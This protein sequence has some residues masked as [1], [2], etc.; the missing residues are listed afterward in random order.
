MT[1]TLIISCIIV[2]ST[3]IKE[4]LNMRKVW[5]G[6]IYSLFNEALWIAFFIMVSRA[7]WPILVAC[8][9]YVVNYSIAIPKWR[10]ERKRR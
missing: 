3:C 9:Y 8:A 4:T 5:W 10:R 7:A 2:V 1:I 6:P